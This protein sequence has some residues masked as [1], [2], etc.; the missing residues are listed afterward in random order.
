MCCHLIWCPCFCRQS[1]PIDSD[2]LRSMKVVQNVGYAPSTGTRRRNQMNYQTSFSPNK[3]KG[4]NV[5]SSPLGRGK[6]LSDIDS[7]SSNLSIPESPEETK[8][9][10]EQNITTCL[11]RMAACRWEQLASGKLTS[12]LVASTLDLLLKRFQ[13]TFSPSP[14]VVPS[15]SFSDSSLTSLDPNYFTSQIPQTMRLNS[16]SFISHDSS[17]M[18]EDLSFR[19]GHSASN[20]SFDSKTKYSLYTS[21][22]G[23]GRALRGQGYLP[24]NTASIG[25]KITRSFSEPWMGNIENTV[26][27]GAEA[28]RLE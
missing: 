9:D 6:N 20:T 3:K 2:I 17:P 22:D 28:K 8:G 13:N 23:S 14:P 1:K 26:S 21:A 25:R 10:T 24:T 5:P 19:S 16:T 18:P 4:K 12:P 15:S 11:Q 7:T 27:K